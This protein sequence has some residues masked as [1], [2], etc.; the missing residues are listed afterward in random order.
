MENLEKQ[1]KI[2]E[3]PDCGWPEGI[4]GRIFIIMG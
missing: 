2:V 3:S 4:S 1:M